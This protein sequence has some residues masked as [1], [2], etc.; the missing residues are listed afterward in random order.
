MEIS[1]GNSYSEDHSMHTLLDN[2]QKSENYSA[3]IVI[4]YS[5]LRREEKF[6]DQKSKLQ[7]DYLNLDNSV[8]NMEREYF[9]QSRFSHCRISHPTDIFLS[10]IKRIGGIISHPSIHE[11]LS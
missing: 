4:N 1:V 2:D 8:R 11:T 10:N 7:I 6:I 3:Q 5:E 9:S